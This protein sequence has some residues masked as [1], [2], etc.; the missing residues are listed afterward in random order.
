[1]MRITSRV[2][3]PAA[4]ALATIG[5]TPALAA[6]SEEQQGAQ[7]L[8]GV[9]T[10]KTSCASLTTAD[11]DHIGEYVMRQML[12]SSA[13]HTAMNRQMVAMMGSR[14]EGQAHVF[15]GRRFAGCTT[16]RAPAA[17]G[18]M[19]GMMG[20]GMMGS[21]YGGSGPNPSSMMSS[22][23]GMMGNGTVGST[24]GGSDWSAGD[25]AIV[26]MLGLLVALVGGALAVW[27]PWRVRSTS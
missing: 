2:L 14:G 3:L 25:T 18:A 6:Q 26:V 15:M 19:M 23:G 11:F 27:R 10:G 12:G 24:A 9:Q 21:A 22:G 4:I 5:V 17:F 7:V 8:S 13:A 1:M 16:G 20:A